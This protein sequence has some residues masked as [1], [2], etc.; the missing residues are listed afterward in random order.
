MW[1]RRLSPFGVARFLGP[2][3]TKKLIDKYLNKR[4]QTDG[5]NAQKEAVA[6]YM[7]QLFMRKSTSDYGLMIMFT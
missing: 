2:R 4:Q 3:Q 5:N 7:F 6:D 1:T